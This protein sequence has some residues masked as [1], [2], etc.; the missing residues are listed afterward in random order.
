MRNL[1]S[2]RLLLRPFTP[3][4]LE[5]LNALH[6]DPDVARYIG[7][8][9]PRTESENRELLDNIFRAYEKEGFG[10]L[11]VASKDSGELLG[12]CGLSLLEVEAAPDHGHPPRW[13]WN[14]GSAPAD[15]EIVRRIEIGY[16]FAK[17]H[18]GHG[19]ATESAAVVRDFAFESLQYGE[20]MAAIA[21]DNHASINVAKKLGL[22]FR[23]PIMAFGKPAK[24]YQIDRDEW[25]SLR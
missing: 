17:A 9:E 4:D 15:V 6:A 10:H 16:T 14:R 24:Q 5:F 8:G 7:Y 12:R 11:A 18:W 20:L 19:Y 13:F 22:S 3:E 2:D 25:E 1:E 21:P 23:G